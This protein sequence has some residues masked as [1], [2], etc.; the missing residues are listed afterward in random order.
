LSSCLR[1]AVAA[2]AAAAVSG[3][4]KQIPIEIIE[5]PAVLYR[6]A[7]ASA[8]ARVRTQMPAAPHVDVADGGRKRRRCHV[9]LWAALQ[10]A[11]VAAALRDRR[12]PWS[13]SCIV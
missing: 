11:L 4:K 8:G 5:F 10:C 13:P 12:L 6:Q 3:T 2:A 7:S 1:P 9:Q